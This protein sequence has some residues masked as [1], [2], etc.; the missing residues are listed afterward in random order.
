MHFQII[1]NHLLNLSSKYELKSQLWTH[2]GLQITDQL[3]KYNLTLCVVCVFTL[4]TDEWC[5]HNRLFN[6]Y[7]EDK[8]KSTPDILQSVPKLFCTYVVVSFDNLSVL[9]FDA[10]LL[11]K[12]YQLLRIVKMTGIREVR[13]INKTILTKS[14]CNVM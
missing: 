10:Y 12:W 14:V 13:F 4:Q 9:N 6:V 5:V 7:F 3:F 11:E 2:H 8:F 1:S